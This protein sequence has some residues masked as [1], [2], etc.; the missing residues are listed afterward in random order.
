MAF[1]KYNNYKIGDK[2]KLIKQ[3]ANCYG[4]F[5]KGSIV[6]ISNINP[7]GFDISDNEGNVVSETSSSNF[8]KYITHKDNILD[9]VTEAKN[10]LTELKLLVLD[11]EKNAVLK[12]YINSTEFNLK[13]FE[14]EIEKLDI[15]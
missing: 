14:K 5:E 15:E 7:R 4:Y 12:S 6:Y 10:K 8:E 11:I 3:V 9:I 1:I 2:V 13:S